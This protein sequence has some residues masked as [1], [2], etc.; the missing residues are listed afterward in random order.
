M[1]K[2]SLQDD[3]SLLSTPARVHSQLSTDDSKFRIT[4]HLAMA[5]DWILDGVIGMFVARMSP[6]VSMSN[7]PGHPDMM[8]RRW[9]DFFPMGQRV[10]VRAGDQVIPEIAVNPDSYLGTWAITVEGADG[11]TTIERHST[12]MGDLLDPARLRFLARRTVGVTVLGRAAVE[13]VAES[14]DEE[15]DIDDVASRLAAAMP[16]F[17]RSEVD[18]MVRN[19]AAVMAS[20]PSGDMGHQES[21][22]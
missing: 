21:D 10:P 12:F 6:S 16:Q 22:A 13:A 4:G 18:R 7:I 1:R 19:L 9:Q 3:S 2:V 20:G 8:D 15:L 17:P 5:R 11:R 14:S